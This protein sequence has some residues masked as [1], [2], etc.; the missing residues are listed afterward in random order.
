MVKEVGAGLAE[1]RGMRLLRRFPVQL[2]VGVVCLL[3][4]LLIFAPPHASSEEAPDVHVLQFTP[5]GT[6]KAVRQVSAR[7][8]EPMVPLGD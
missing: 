4:L 1:S 5:Q 8:S 3:L 2:K 6:V 7:F